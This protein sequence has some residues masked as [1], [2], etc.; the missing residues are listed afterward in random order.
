MSETTDRIEKK[1]LLRSPR[2][3]VW[4][5]LTDPQEFGT[6]FGM[7]FDGPFVPGN[8]VRGTIVPTTV[9]ATVAASQR[10]YEGTS[11]EL[12]IERMEPE[13][14]FSFRWH[15]YAVEASVDYSIEPMTLVR[16]ELEET[17]NGVLLTVV[18]SGFD[19]IPITRRAKAFD[20]NSGGWNM[21]IQ[22]IEKFLAQTA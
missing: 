8:R 4:R 3:R 7:R 22:L 21:Q 18:E 16:F 20:A 10:R 13:R 19:K 1:V 9:D 15:P 17:S 2:T 14:L 5:A 12:H 6:W 11:F